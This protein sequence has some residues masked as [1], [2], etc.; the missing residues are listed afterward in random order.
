MRTGFIGLGQI[1]GPMAR[2]LDDPV[3]YDVSA[4]ATAGFT[5]VA[6]SVAEVAEASDVISVMVRT[7]D[8]VRA[9]VGELARAARDGSVI[10][11]H[12]T[13]A[14]GT[15]EAM[16][17]DVAGRGI[18]VVDAPV[19]GGAIGASEG[20]LG[21]MVGG[22]AGAAER[23]RPAFE[24]WSSLFLHVGPV[25]SAT[26]LKLAL[27]LLIFTSFAA[28]IEAQSLAETAGIDLRLLTQVVRHSDSITGGPSAIMFR[29]TT[30]PVTDDDPVRPI[31]EHTRELGEKDLGL[32]VRLAADLGV[33]VPLARLALRD[34]PARLGVPH[35]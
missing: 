4:D 17:D 34:L 12:S 1:G 32:A 14:P 18:A 6:G 24:P 10:A 5:S 30:A 35:R 31:L 15:A 21:V 9:V 26:T 7:D 3:V 27:N 19:T 29:R 33:D 11:V 22:D 28:A 2:R 20:T 23:C 8:Q 16:A 13:I 25:G